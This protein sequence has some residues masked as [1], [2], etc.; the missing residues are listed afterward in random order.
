[1]SR[2]FT[3][4]EKV[5][6]LILAVLLLGC[7]YY[8]LVLQP[9]WDALS[10][11]EKRL[12]SV[13][14]EIVVQQGVAVQR[15]QLQQQISEAEDSGAAQKTLPEFDNTKNAISEL[16]GILADASSYSIDFSEVEITDSMARRTVSISFTTDSYAA[17]QSVLMKLVDCRYSCLVTDY[18]ITGNNLGQSSSSGEVSASATIVFFEKTV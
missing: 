10:A 9:S 18:A 5:L 14:N 16:N 11:S 6:M 17:A 7:C 15:A 2:T 12:A 13:Q 4:R 3:M 1:M 8:L